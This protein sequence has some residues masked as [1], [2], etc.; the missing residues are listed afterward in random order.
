[1]PCVRSG[2]WSPGRS[3]IAIRDSSGIRRLT[4]LSYYPLGPCLFGLG[5]ACTVVLCIIL[6]RPAALCPDTRV[7]T[8]SRT[9]WWRPRSRG[10]QAGGLVHRI[11]FVRSR[12]L[13][14]VTPGLNGNNGVRTSA[15]FLAV[16]R[17]PFSIRQFLPASI[18]K[19]GLLC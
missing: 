18:C 14:T 6:V 8:T 3:N 12:S 2:K 1:M 4:D 10:L 13:A 15:V 5:G 19:I 17:T 16:Q 7:V 11:A 9:S